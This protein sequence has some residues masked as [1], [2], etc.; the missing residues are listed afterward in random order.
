MSKTKPSGIVTPER[1]KRD[2]ENE[3]AALEKQIAETGTEL[4]AKRA[5]LVEARDAI[6]AKIAE[7]RNQIAG[8]DIER[9]AAEF[10]AVAARLDVAQTVADLAAFRRLASELSMAGRVRQAYAAR[11]SL[12]KRMLGETVYSMPFPNWSAMARAWLIPAQ[13]AA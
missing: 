9:K 2:L 7:V 8:E 6:E 1:I 13:K 12:I 10:L 4:E 11:E 5:K 3:I